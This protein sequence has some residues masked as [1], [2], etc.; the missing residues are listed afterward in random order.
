[1]KPTASWTSRDEEEQVGYRKGVADLKQRPNFKMRLL[2]EGFQKKKKL[3]IPKKVANSES[4]N[5]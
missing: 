3:Q 4:Q 2:V 5:L 1:M